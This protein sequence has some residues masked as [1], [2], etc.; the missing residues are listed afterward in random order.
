MPPAMLWW[1]ERA[2]IRRSSPGSYGLDR[3]AYGLRILGIGA[4]AARSASAAPVAGHPH[5]DDLK[6]TASPLNLPRDESAPSHHLRDLHA[7]SAPHGQAGA[8]APQREHG[9][10]AAGPADRGSDRGAPAAAQAGPQPLAGVF[11]DPP[12]ASQCTESLGNL[13]LV[14]KA[15]N[16]KA[17]NLDFARKHAIYFPPSGGPV[18]AINEY[19]HR[20]KVW[21]P[22]QVRERDEDLMKRLQALWNLGNG[23]SRRTRAA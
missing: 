15:Q 22:A 8:A 4:Q 9:R 20:Q 16:D 10:R 21:T 19:V 11:P 17:G 2:R 12:S 6:A 23:E 1:L 5:G 18:L 14:T 13:V 7:R 3:L